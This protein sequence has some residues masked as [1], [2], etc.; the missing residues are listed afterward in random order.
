MTK[1]DILEYFKD[2]NHYYNNCMMFD[3]LN[4]M[5]NELIET[6]QSKLGWIGVKDRLPEDD[7]AVLAVKQLKDGRRDMCLARC[8]PNYECYD[9]ETRSII[10][11]PYWVC[12]GNNN[13]I[14][15]MPLP[16]P[17]KEGT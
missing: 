15:W 14:Y 7:R 12:G 8:I 6:E 4:S 2:I 3:S 13:I 10:K 11:N 17:P 5:L 16:E 1:H 9:V